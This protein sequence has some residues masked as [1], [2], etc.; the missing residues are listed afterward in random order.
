MEKQLATYAIR[1]APII[2]KTERAPINKKKY[3]LK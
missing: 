3:V 2:L 1:K